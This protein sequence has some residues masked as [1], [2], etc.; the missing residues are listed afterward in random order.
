MGNLDALQGKLKSVSK[1]IVP[2]IFEVLA[3]RLIET[4]DPDYLDVSDSKDLNDPIWKIVRLRKLEVA[5]LN[6][7]LFQRLRHVRQ[8]GLA[9]L[10]YPTAVHS[11]LD[12]SIGT[13]IAARRM[14][15]MILANT[16]KIDQA[17]AKKFGEIASFAALLHDA[18]HTAFS[19]CGETVLSTMLPGEFSRIEKELQTFYSKGDGAKTFKESKRPPAAELISVLFVLSPSMRRFLTNHEIPVAIERFILTAAGLIIGRGYQLEEGDDEFNFISSIVSGDLDADKIDYVARDAYFSGVPISADVDRLISQLVAAPV[20]KDTTVNGKQA[21]QHL[22]LNN[23]TRYDL[24]IRRAGISAFEMFVMTRSYLFERIYSHQKIRAA[25]RALERTVRLFVGHLLPDIAKDD[26]DKPES[27]KLVTEGLQKVFD[28]LFVA[29]G[30][31]GVLHEMLRHGDYEEWAN[32]IL[33][34]RLPMRGLAIN[35]RVAKEFVADGNGTPMSILLPFKYVSRIATDSA[36]LREL[37]TEIKASSGLD[38]SDYVIIDWPSFNPVS[39]NPK[40][41]VW[42]HKEPKNLSTLSRYFNVQQLSNAYRD[43]KQTAWVFCSP[44]NRVKVGVTT[45]LIL[46]EKFDLLLGMEAFHRAKLLD[47]EVT[48]YLNHL[49]PP[50]GNERGRIALDNLR[51]NI[52]DCRLIPSVK[53]LEEAFADLEEPE[54]PRVANKIESAFLTH[55]FL[56]GYSDHLA[57]AMA[58]LAFLIRHAQTTI[59]NFPQPS[60]KARVKGDEDLAPDAASEDEK[61]KKREATFQQSVREFVQADR[62][63]NARFEI[64][65]GGH[66]GGGAFDLVFQSKTPPMV[67]VVVELKSE[68]AKYEKIYDRSAGQPS[69]YATDRFGRASILYVQYKQMESVSVS[70]TIELRRAS[71]SNQVTFCL[72]QNA[73]GGKPSERGGGTS[74][75][76]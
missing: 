57:E 21:D 39:E 60:R 2:Y 20:T 12:H 44:S 71:G 76:A 72:A 67:S 52:L 31:D 18:G 68:D 66:V 59:G 8:L 24:G 63:T 54:I 61:K 58:V 6:L 3:P 73:F 55:P 48:D 29:T 64:I 13:M 10:V 5:L 7:P 28:L 17:K 56:R 46:E 43:V 38:E 27:I 34:R 36:Q 51:Q 1:F 9:H 25:E 50:I 37:E 19:H 4:T 41:Y 11:R 22:K 40:L 33:L 15:E 74:K 65:D 26:R 45:A 42:D 47:H 23:K 32:R 53:Q 62:A 75:I 16:D 35:Q 30:D 49:S 14:Y 69:V 70:D